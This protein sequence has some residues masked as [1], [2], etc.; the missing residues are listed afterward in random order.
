MVR[1]SSNG[2]GA[3][4]VPFGSTAAVPRHNPYAQMSGVG[5][6]ATSPGMTLGAAR[7]RPSA[8]QGMPPASQQHTSVSRTTEISDSAQLG[9]VNQQLPQLFAPPQND[10][11]TSQDLVTTYS[12]FGHDPVDPYT[13]FGSGP[14]ATYSASGNS[15]DPL[16]G[17]DQTSAVMTAYQD[18]STEH[19][20][21]SADNFDD[22]TE[23]QL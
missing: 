13:A 11:S 16:D 5:T 15:L 1:G 6:S 17:S 10:P 22:M 19:G 2:G 3:P 8:K 14:A 20:N 21:N 23:L 7:G 9:S 4:Q 12:S 18:D